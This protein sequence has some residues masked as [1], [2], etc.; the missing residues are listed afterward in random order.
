MGEIME[1]LLNQIF[2][3]VILIVCMVFAYIGCHMSVE[4]DAKKHIPLLWEKG[5]FLNKQY[6]KYFDKSNVKYFDGDNT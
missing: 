2:A 1:E 3:G 5:G 6:H 4:K